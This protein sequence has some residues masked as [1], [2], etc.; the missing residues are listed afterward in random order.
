MNNR[1]ETSKRRLNYLTFDD[2]SK[3]AS[4]MMTYWTS[5]SSGSRQ[6]ES[7][8]DCDLERD[9]LVQLRDLKILIDKEKDHR[10]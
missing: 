1:F 7:L 3:S 8:D 10:K 5:T 9:F 4:A 6:S 2:F